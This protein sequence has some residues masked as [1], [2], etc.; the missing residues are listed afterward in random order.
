MEPGLADD[1]DIEDSFYVDSGLSYNG[2]PTSSLTGLDHL[3]GETVSILADGAIHPD[4]TVASGAIT[5]DY[6]VTKAHV[7]YAFNSDVEPMQIDGGSADGTAQGKLK[8]VTD[9]TARLYRTV[10]LLVGP[11]ADTLDRVPFRSSAD[12][13]DAPVALFTGNKRLPFPSG[14]E[15]EA[16]IYLRQNQPLPFTVLAII[17]RV[18]T[19][20]L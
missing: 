10:G 1:E 19:N 2:S 4:K 9:V 5:L 11:D 20:S 16:R 18:K 12:A 6:E 13:M 17:T 8:R 3:E 7:G 14:A 15:R